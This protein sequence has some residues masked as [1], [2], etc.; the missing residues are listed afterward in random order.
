M[1]TPLVLP[2]TPDRL[3]DRAVL[4]RTLARQ[5][6]QSDVVGLPALAG[7]DTWLGPRPF[8][9]EADLRRL[10]S[11]FKL[12]AADLRSAAHLLDVQAD[13]ASATRGPS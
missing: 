4:L 7:S 2:P 8:D 6:D 5:L 12:A 13:A 11:R 10:V 1:G 9:C 3:R